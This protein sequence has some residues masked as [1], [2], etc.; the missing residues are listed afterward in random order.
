MIPS[1]SYF[2]NTS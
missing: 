1:V 2:Q